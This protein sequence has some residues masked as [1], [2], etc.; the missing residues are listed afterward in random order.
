MDALLLPLMW[1]VYRAM[2]K[3]QATMEA[4]AWNGKRFVRIARPMDTKDG[5]DAANHAVMGWSTVF[6]GETEMFFS[7]S[8]L[9]SSG[10]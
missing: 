7:T 8:D 3:W 5:L 2:S 10:V 9:Q 6:A 1:E 4:L